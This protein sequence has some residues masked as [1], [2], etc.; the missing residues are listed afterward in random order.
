MFRI[1][2]LERRTFRVFTWDIYTDPLSVA[3][4]SLFYHSPTMTS[5][6]SSLDQAAPPTDSDSDYHDTREARSPSPSAVNTS[7]S[8]TGR[9]R[10]GSSAASP[11]PQTDIPS[12]SK[13]RWK[14]LTD[15]FANM[16]RHQRRVEAA[17]KFTSK[18]FIETERSTAATNPPESSLPIS[19]KSQSLYKSTGHQY[20][21][22][23][24]RAISPNSPHSTDPNSR[25]LGF[26]SSL[27]PQSTPISAPQRSWLSRTT[28]MSRDEWRGA[29]IALSRH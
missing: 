26:D 7:R 21:T 3:I 23:R 15:S 20:R 9:W 27:R 22:H 12:F 14:K 6:N 28:G 2:Y 25:P 18:T 13:R 4:H 5:Y 24:G 17:R 11:L 1:T 8:G 10:T 19:E 16:G 29:W